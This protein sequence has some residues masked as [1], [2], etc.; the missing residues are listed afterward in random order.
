MPRI[1]RCAASTSTWHP[2]YRVALV[3]PS[4][5]GKTTLAN[6]LVRFLDHDGTVALDGIEI[7]R[8]SSDDVRGAVGL[9]AQDAHIFDTTIEENLRLAKRD[10]TAN[11]IDAALRKVRLDDWVGSLPAGLQTETGPGGSRLS[12]GQRRRLVIARALLRDFPV[13]VLDEPG[14]HLDPPTADAILADVLH[15]TDGRSALIITHRLEGLDGIDE[16]MTL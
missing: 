4:G 12:G 15:A 7:D 6:V 13:L 9:V 10:A 8:L 1:P 5:C 14:E 2:G 11:E 16:V 3:G